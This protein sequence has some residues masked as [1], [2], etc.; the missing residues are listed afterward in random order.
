MSNKMLGISGIMMYSF[1]WTVF[2]ANFG[3]VGLSVGL[4]AVFPDFKS[5]NSAR[6]VS[7]FGGTLNLMISLGFILL[8]VTL[9]VIPFQLFLKGHISSYTAL[10]NAVLVSIGLISI[11]GIML[12]IFP[13][14]YGIRKFENAQF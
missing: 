2:I 13:L 14:L 5:E 12:C 1:L 3:V 9:I 10:I 4:G 8:T 6:I 11:L 7:G